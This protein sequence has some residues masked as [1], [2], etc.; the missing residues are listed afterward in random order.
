M[1]ALLRSGPRSSRLGVGSVGLVARSASLL[2]RRCYQG[3]LADKDRI[4]TNL[5][6]DSSPYLDAAKKRVKQQPRPPAAELSVAARSS[7]AIARSARLVPHRGT[8]ATA[9]RLDA[10][11]LFIV[12]GW[13]GAPLTI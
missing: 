5:Y 8:C 9:R 2:Q 6:N 11:C 12:Q 7:L 1:A 13:G 10:V 4:F 3:N